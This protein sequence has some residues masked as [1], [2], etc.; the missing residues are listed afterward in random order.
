M[1]DGAQISPYG[2]RR[3][4]AMSE[5]EISGSLETQRKLIKLNLIFVIMFSCSF[6]WDILNG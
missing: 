6:N 5:D 2:K 3:F 1:K 4:H